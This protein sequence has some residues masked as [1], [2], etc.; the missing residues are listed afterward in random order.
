MENPSRRSEST[1]RVGSNAERVL[2]VDVSDPSAVA[3]FWAKVDRT[4]D[5]WTWTAALRRPGGYGQFWAAGR[6]V[7]AHRFA[8]TLLVGPIP[9]GLELDHLC[10]NHACVNP[11]HLEPVTQ[12]V[13]LLRGVGFC[14]ANARRTECPQGHPL[15]GANLYV[16][17]DGRRKC[18]ECKNA[19]GRASYAS[20]NSLPLGSGK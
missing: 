11:E 1:T 2:P 6:M 3:R 17:P 19:C 16:R 13:N 4:G 12:A 20:K 9:A 15:S 14:A 8:F 7:G 10:R 18:R 5:C